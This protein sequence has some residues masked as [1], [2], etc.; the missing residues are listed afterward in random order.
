MVEQ[1]K[2]QL[3]LLNPGQSYDLDI[4]EL[5]NLICKLIGIDP[6]KFKISISENKDYTSFKKLDEDEQRL[7]AFNRIPPQNIYQ[8]KLFAQRNP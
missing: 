4:E 5:N 6:N 8:T 1:L 3:R 7:H 2:K